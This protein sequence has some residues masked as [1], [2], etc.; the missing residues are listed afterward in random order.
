M[1]KFKNYSFTAL[2]LAMV[3]ATLM[4]GS[5]SSS[6]AQSGFSLVKVI[7]SASEAVPTTVTNSPTVKLAT[8]ASVTVNNGENN[9][10]LVQSVNDGVTPF[11]QVVI[12]PI[13]N[14][15]VSG[16]GVIAVPSGQRLVI[17]YASA[18]ISVPAG[19]NIHQLDIATEIRGTRVQH[20]LLRNNNG[21]S[22]N[23]NDIF[24]AGQQ[25]RLY[26]DGDTAVIFNVARNTATGSG[27]LT[28][29]VS[30]YL[31]KIP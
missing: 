19:Q 15:S 20:N 25:L 11:H 12:S 7:N 26:A 31:M 18:F 22:F 4:V 5:A 14:G 2:G 9:P 13:P 8:G 28:V 10:V 24:T 23:G 30:G 27:S 6:I 3:I 1:Q 21:T 29:T 16:S 17:E